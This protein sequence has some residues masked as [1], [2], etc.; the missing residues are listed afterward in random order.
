MGPSIGSSFF[1]AQSYYTTLVR[2][3]FKNNN[4]ALNLQRA[5][6]YI[7]YLSVLNATTQ[8]CP[9]TSEYSSVTST[10]INDA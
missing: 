3:R 2:F 6:V 1:K 7:Y 8:K 4:L 5:I 10:N 9:N